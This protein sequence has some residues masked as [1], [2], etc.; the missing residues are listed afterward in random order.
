MLEDEQLSRQLE[1]L[2]SQLVTQRHRQA[3]MEVGYRMVEGTTGIMLTVWQQTE[4]LEA[5]RVEMAIAQRRV[6]VELE[7]ITG[8]PVGV[9]SGGERLA[10]AAMTI[11][12]S[13]EP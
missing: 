9:A 7:Q 10:E 12:T 1:L 11:E 3:V 5:R 4:D 2:G 13:A 8:M 6:V